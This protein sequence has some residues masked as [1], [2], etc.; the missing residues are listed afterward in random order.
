MISN[1]KL[2]YNFICE[3]SIL[4]RKNLL[5]FQNNICLIINVY[6][7]NNHVITLQKYHHFT[8]LHHVTSLQS[9][10]ILRLLYKPPYRLHIIQNKS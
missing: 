10:Y 4:Q 9:M 1:I 6:I 5:T 2:I 3:H 7:I 8:V